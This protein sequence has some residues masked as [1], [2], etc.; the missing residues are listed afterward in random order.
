MHKNNYFAIILLTLLVSLNVLSSFGH[1]LLNTPHGK[2]FSPISDQFHQ[3]GDNRYYFAHTREVREDFFNFSP[4]VGANESFKAFENMRVSVYRFLYLLGGYF[5]DARLA[6]ISSHVLSIILGALSLYFFCF[7]SG[8]GNLESILITLV[9]TYLYP[10]VN[11]LLKLEP[12]IGLNYFWSKFLN[13]HGNL[14]IENLNSNFRYGIMSGVMFFVWATLSLIMFKRNE[15][16]IN[17]F[18]IILLSIAI[19]ATQYTYLPTTLYI[20]LLISIYLLINLVKKPYSSS[21]ELTIS[22]FGSI[23]LFIV[24]NG[25]STVLKFLNNIP[26][27]INDAHFSTDQNLPIKLGLFLTVGGFLPFIF[28]LSL[29]R[30]KKSSVGFD[31][32]LANQLTFIFLALTFLVT[33]KETMFFRLFERGFGAIY[34]VGIVFLIF[35]LFEIIPKNK[36]NIVFK[37][38]IAFIVLTVLFSTFIISKQMMKSNGYTI[39]KSR[40]EMY[41]FI[42]QKVNRNSRFFTTSYADMQLMPSFTDQDLVV[43]GAEYYENPYRSLRTYFSG[44]A[45]FMN[46]QLVGKDW[47]SHYFD[48][49][50]NK[51]CSPM[52]KLI[53]KE[54]SL[55]GETLKQLMY[56]P[57]VKFV[58]NIQ[59]RDR[60]DKKFSDNFISLFHTLL[61]DSGKDSKAFLNNGVDYILISP[62]FKMTNIP[63][64]YLSYQIDGFFLLK[65]ITQ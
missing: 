22:L 30:Q 55:G 19:F 37:F 21:K 50:S 53:S 18:R 60:N 34:V 40:F 17:Y 5:D 6:F 44:M 35:N 58:N 31:F 42:N 11:S 59:I 7:F 26:P 23:A 51:R 52:P 2:V 36:K 8:M 32:I 15:I 25:H 43:G 41:Q 47:L 28:L 45:W 39:E 3:C 63:G 57:Y 20:D 29:N 24:F 49:V 62:P 16:K 9:C 12:N 14:F 1:T 65:K 13:I 33:N 64:F 54:H 27:I 38:L 10:V 46:I 4:P 61:I 56:D 48:Y